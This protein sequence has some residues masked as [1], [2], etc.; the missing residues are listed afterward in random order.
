MSNCNASSLWDHNQESKGTSEYW[1]METMADLDA[2]QPR[3][4]IEDVLALCR[5]ICTEVSL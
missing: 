4:W 1:R 3:Q 5:R 2:D